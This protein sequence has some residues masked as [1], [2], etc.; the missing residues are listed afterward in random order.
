VV[1]PVDDAGGP[2]GLHACLMNEESAGALDII[3]GER[4]TGQGGE[5]VGDS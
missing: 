3:G 4:H 1:V 2:G 5:E